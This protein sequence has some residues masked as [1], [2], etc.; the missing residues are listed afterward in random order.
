MSRLAY[1]TSENNLKQVPHCSTQ[2]GLRPYIITHP[3]KF[4]TSSHQLL[5]FIILADFARMSFAVALCHDLN[6]FVC[7]Q[8]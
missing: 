8:I 1:T 4:I 3:D 6:L 5:M 7:I 2:V